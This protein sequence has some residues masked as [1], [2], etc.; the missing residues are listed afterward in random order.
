MF[1]QRPHYPPVNPSMTPQTRMAIT[2]Q[3]CQLLQH[4]ALQ[5]IQAHGTPETQAL[6]QFQ[7]FSYLYHVN[8]QL[9]THAHVQRATPETVNNTCNMSRPCNIPMQVLTRQ[10]TPCNASSVHACM[11]MH[12]YMWTCPRHA[13]SSSM[14]RRKAETHAKCYGIV[15]QFE[16][17]FSSYYWVSGTNCKVL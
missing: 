17:I 1:N 11:H 4:L 2:F 3:P 6:Q 8:V 16:K 9:L 5:R 10:Q 7:P 13:C 15:T 12:M 14:W